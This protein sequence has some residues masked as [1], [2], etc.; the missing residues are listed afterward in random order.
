MAYEGKMILPEFYKYMHSFLF[1]EL[2]T[3]KRE[4]TAYPPQPLSKVQLLPDT[5]N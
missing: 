4:R 3:R 5:Q 2:S 1:T